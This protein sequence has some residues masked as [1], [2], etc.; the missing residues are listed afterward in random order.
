MS[1][2]PQ[3]CSIVPTGLRV[4]PVLCPRTEVLGYRS[5]AP[6]GLGPNLF[7]A[8]SS[9]S[10]QWLRPGAVSPLRMTVV[11][12]VGY[13]FFTAAQDD[14]WFDGAMRGWRSS[15]GDFNGVGRHAGLLRAFLPFLIPLRRFR[16]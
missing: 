5:I 7:G 10:H 16:A 13:D 2:S 14:G 9:F 4:L 15:A 3:R 1:V 8:F 11:Q 12:R 6:P